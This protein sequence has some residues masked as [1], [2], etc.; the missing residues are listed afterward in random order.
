M[1]TISIDKT[2]GCQMFLGAQSAD[3]VQIVSAKSSEMNVVL[4]DNVSDR[5]GDMVCNTM[6][7]C[8]QL[9]FSIIK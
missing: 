5:D 6:F 8:Y 4:V 3:C 7:L 1:P 2:D 9:K